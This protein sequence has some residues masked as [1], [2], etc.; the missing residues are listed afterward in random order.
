MG[1]RT[2]N[3]GD[4]AHSRQADIA[5]VL[6]AAMKE[7]VVLLAPEPGSNPGLVR[8]RLSCHSRPRCSAQYYPSR[9]LE[10]HQLAALL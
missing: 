5:D 1:N 9:R 6:A 8:N 7:T 3:E 4:V 2:A 10:I